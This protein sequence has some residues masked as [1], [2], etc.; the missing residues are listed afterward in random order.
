MLKL[1]AEL[2]SR[3]NDDTWNES[4]HH[5]DRANGKAHTHT[6][7]RTVPPTADGFK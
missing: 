1:R 4:E 5:G 6:H 7:T 2:V 3:A